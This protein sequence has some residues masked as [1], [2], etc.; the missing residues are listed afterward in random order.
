MQSKLFQ[1]DK[2]TKLESDPR[3]FIRLDILDS[4]SYRPEFLP[5]AIPKTLSDE[6]VMLHSNPSA[7]FISQDHSSST[8]VIIGNASAKI[9]AFDCFAWE[10][11][12][13]LVDYRERPA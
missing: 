12:V 1:A 13:F 5:L 2:N 3:Q 7:F 4:S 6:L 10:P 11:A 8:R 9:N